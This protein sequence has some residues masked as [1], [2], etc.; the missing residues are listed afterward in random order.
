LEV[1]TEAGYSVEIT[2]NQQAKEDALL[3]QYF[4]IAL[5]GTS[6]NS[7]RVSITHPY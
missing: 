6:F 3:K 4:K 2:L 7:T 5:S 1:H